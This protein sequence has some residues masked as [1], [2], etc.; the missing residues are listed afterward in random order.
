MDKET[1]EIE[2]AEELLTEI[3]NKSKKD[4]REINIIIDKLWKGKSVKLIVR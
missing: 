2:K 3:V 4:I 1:E